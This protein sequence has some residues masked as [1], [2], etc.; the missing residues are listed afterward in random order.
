[1]AERQGYCE[2]A[3]PLGENFEEKKSQKNLGE[4]LRIKNFKWIGPLVRELLAGTGIFQKRS[5]DCI[6]T[7]AYLSFCE[8]IYHALIYILKNRFLSRFRLAVTSQMTSDSRRLFSLSVSRL[9][10]QEKFYS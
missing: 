3:Y 7:G 9:I 1:M 4:K 8:T 6:I 5:E 2:P 10:L